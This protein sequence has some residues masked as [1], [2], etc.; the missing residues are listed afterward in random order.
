MPPQSTRLAA[1]LLFVSLCLTT[2]LRAADNKSDIIARCKKATALVD[3]G[4]LGSGSA[5][6]VDTTGV[7]LT[8][9]H[10]I[11][12]RGI[13]GTVTLVLN[14][15]EKNE[16]L[17]VARVASVSEEHD[18]A[19]LLA[20]DAKDLTALPLDQ[21]EAITEVD[22][23]TA[24]GF[25]FGKR[26]S[27]KAGEYPSVSINTGK[28][29]ALRKRDGELAVIQ[30]DA[31]V[32]PGNSGGPLVN[33]AGE[34]VGVIV[35]GN[36]AAR[37]AF[38]I[39]ARN[40]TELLQRPALLI[41]H[42]EVAY[43]DRYQP[44]PFTVDV[45]ELTSDSAPDAM[46][47]EVTNELDAVRRFPGKKVGRTFEFQVSPLESTSSDNRLKLM[48]RQGNPAHE[49]VV[50]DRPV[51]VGKQEL[52]LSQIRKI[53]RR[54]QRQFVTCTSDLKLAGPVS[55]LEDLK[56]PDGTAVDLASEL[57]LDVF[58]IRVGPLVVQT[59]FTAS[60]KGEVVATVRQDFSLANPPRAV[61]DNPYDPADPY[62]PSPD[63]IIVEV[64]IDGEDE[65]I[66]APDGLQLHHKSYGKPGDADGAMHYALVNGRRWNLKWSDTTQSDPRPDTTELYPLKLG[67]E[68]WD[69]EVLLAHTNHLV[70]HNP[71]HGHVSAREEGPN[72][73]V[74]INDGE[75]GS[76]IYRLRLKKKFSRSVP[77]A[78]VYQM[79][80]P[81]PASSFELPAGTAIDALSLV[82][83][84]DHI[85]EGHFRRDDG[86]LVSDL[87]TVT[88]LLFP[89]MVGGGYELECDFQRT[90]GDKQIVFTLPVGDSACDF[91]LAADNRY[92]GLQLLDGREVKEVPGDSGAVRETGALINGKK[93]RLKV[94]V[95]KVEPDRVTITATLD[96]RPLVNWTGNPA[97][98]A[99]SPQQAPP[100]FQAF[101]IRSW[102]SILR[103]Q[104]FEVTASGDTKICGLGDDWK[105]LAR[106][107]SAG[108]AKEIAA[109]C[110][111]WNGR[112]YFV[113]EAPMN[114][115][116]AQRLAAQMGGRLVTI[117]TADEEA[118]LK[119]QFPDRF[120]WLATW[121]KPDS[122]D[123]RDDRNR[124]QTFLPPWA[125]K[126]PDIGAGE[127]DLAYG[128]FADAAQ[129]KSG[130]HDMHATN[131]LPHACIEWGD[132]SSAAP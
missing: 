4:S 38:A 14:P 13:G 72:Y 1:A 77:A 28:V 78:S 22:S 11:D 71:K 46:D 55:G 40:V 39:P 20:P 89:V 56:W 57:C 64:R 54:D 63:S 105:N 73:I 23:V 98:L 111:T 81:H 60:R 114:R 30:I 128:K 104:K 129:Y 7:F 112:Q 74:N 124:L 110:A 132:E 76:S 47:L 5:F 44:C 90:S 29:T 43:A 15:T 127:C 107:I 119:T 18:L 126:Q 45:I 34:V 12:S 52:R 79:P 58:A 65:L 103:L 131:A 109:K 51:R 21:A 82:R 102:N 32:N 99:N 121:R 120:L 66:V 35:S 36:Q 50:T 93:Y 61:P 96:N 62:S 122:S 70:P 130:L 85:L 6:C 27:G 115:A 117:S 17:L 49:L 113:S 26:L 19:V 37:L 116:D 16:R 108:P 59:E 68:E 94:K 80:S 53:E 24:Y 8:N 86:D 101:S 88:R 125:E 97:Q 69:F 41:K 84:P 25:P 2:S 106:P 31:A 100:V 3:L 83:L 75:F 87:N 42:P 48:S 95:A 9:N 10:V 118:F 33:D 92:S 67:Y 123:W 91:V